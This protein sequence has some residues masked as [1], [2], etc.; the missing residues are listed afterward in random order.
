MANNPMV[1]EWDYVGL[2]GI[3]W[4]FPIFSHISWWF[5][6]PQWL[7]RWPFNTGADGHYHPGFPPDGSTRHPDARRLT[8]GGGQCGRAK[9]R[10]KGH[11][12]VPVAEILW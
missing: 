9:K 7:L 1:I 6:N 5:L 8:P 4:D 11:P 10:G 3:M 12:V 2:C